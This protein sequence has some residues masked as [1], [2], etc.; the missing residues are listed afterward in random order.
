MS[1]PSFHD[2]GELFV[3]KV[4]SAG[5]N[6]NMFPPLKCFS[7]QNPKCKITLRLVRPLFTYANIA[8]VPNLI[9]DAT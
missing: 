4:K 2:A 9:P 6:R 7:K 1:I 8:N 5:G 3:K